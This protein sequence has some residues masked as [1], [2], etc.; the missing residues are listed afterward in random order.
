MRLEVF[1]ENVI[2]LV[3][4]CVALHNICEEKGH[5]VLNDLDEPA[6]FVVPEEVASLAHRQISARH[7]AEGRRVR[8]ALAQ[9]MYQHQQH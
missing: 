7:K 8:D 6:T 1:F 3:C 4:A 5:A 2:P 9:F